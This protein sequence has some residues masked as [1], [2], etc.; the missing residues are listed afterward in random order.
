VGPASQRLFSRCP[1]R[2]NQ[3]PQAAELLPHPTPK[4]SCTTADYQGVR[5]HAT[6][7]NA[8]FRTLSVE[9]TC[10]IDFPNGLPGFEERR[11]F[12]ALTFA[13]SEPVVFLKSLEDQACVL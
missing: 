12:R 10:T 11:R 8:E 1:D 2:Q 3:N 6:F 4:D 13:D 7:S 9:E 5:R